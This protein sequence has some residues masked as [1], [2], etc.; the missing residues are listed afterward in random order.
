MF[1]PCDPGRNALSLF[2]RALW[3]SPVSP[4]FQP[5][6]LWN[7]LG[8]RRRGWPRSQPSVSWANA[9]WVG[10]N[11]TSDSL[12]VS[13][14]CQ[15]IAGWWRCTLHSPLGYRALKLTSI[16]RA[17]QFEKSQRPGRW[18]FLELTHQFLS[19]S[20]E[21]ANFRSLRTIITW[22]IQSIILARL[23]I[24]NDSS[25]S[26]LNS[27]CFF[28]IKRGKREL[29]N[30]AK[31]WDSKLENDTASATGCIVL[32]VKIHWNLPIRHPWAPQSNC[33]C[34]CKYWLLY[35]LV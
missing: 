30:E 8:A 7:A 13:G 10:L 26:N 15:E 17:H 35:Y 14:I 28:A 25:L 29:D 34:P 33:E 16:H 12:S 9:P 2:K 4:N 18:L 22:L 24:I 21:C 32:L 3:K 20:G 23:T 6:A 5:T 27:S 1:A 31:E 19:L 11:T